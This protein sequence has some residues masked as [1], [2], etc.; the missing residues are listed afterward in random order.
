[1]RPFRRLSLPAHAL[2]ELVVGLA[3]VAAS[4]TLDL[5][6]AGTVLTFAAGVIVTGMGFGAADSM[7]LAVHQSLDRLMVTALA[8]GSIIAALAGSG[9]ASVLL[10]AGAAAQLILT[11][12]T[13]WTRTPLAR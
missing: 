9:L 8:A 13:R 6:T 10:L 5:G 2:V 3:F 12:V 4:L 7:P 11:G 1:M